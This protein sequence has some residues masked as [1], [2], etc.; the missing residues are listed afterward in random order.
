MEQA[1]STRKKGA[2]SVS[3]E[4]FYIDSLK[5]APNIWKF[6]EQGEPV[7]EVKHASDYSYSSSSY[8]WPYVRVV[9]DAGCFIDPYFSSGVHLALVSGLSAA[10]TIS[11]VI[12]GDCE[13]PV[14]AKW[15][16]SKVADGY[17]RFLLVVTS[18]YRQIRNQKEF[19][20][21]DIGADNIDEAFDFFRPGKPLLLSFFSICVRSD[22]LLMVIQSSKG[23]RTQLTRYPMR[24]LPRRLISAPK[25]GTRCSRRSVPHCFASWPRPA[26][27]NQTRRCHAINSKRL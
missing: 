5:L 8:A 3:A 6:L 26:L 10:T 14:A 25:P 1:L 19:I 20:L 13:E 4:D 9:G 24:N 21:S 23:R 27:S 16:S 12:K 15:H 17:A 22:R 18:A 7:T 11:A 2:S